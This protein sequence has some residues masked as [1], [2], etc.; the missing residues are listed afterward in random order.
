MQ[1]GE[2]VKALSQELLISRGLLFEWRLQAERRSGG[3][4]SQ[5][6]RRQGDGEVQAL[7]ARIAELEA[8]IGRTMLERD[9]LASALRRIG[10]ANPSSEPAGKKTSGPRSADRW[11]RKAN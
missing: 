3:S 7:E 8:A 11:N 2:R 6:Q 5:V 10:M 4:P 9:F 1:E